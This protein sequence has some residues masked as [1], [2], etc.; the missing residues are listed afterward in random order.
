[1]QRPMQEQAAP[2]DVGPF[3]PENSDEI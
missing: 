3:F 1:M 2:V